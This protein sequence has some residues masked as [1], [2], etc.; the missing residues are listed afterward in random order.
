MLK[1]TT[2]T[3]IV[4]QEII[5]RYTYLEEKENMRGHEYNRKWMVHMFGRDTADISIPYRTH[6]QFENHFG[7]LIDCDDEMKKKNETDKLIN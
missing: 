1:I 7:L 3:R 4:H 2:L 6:S 5:T